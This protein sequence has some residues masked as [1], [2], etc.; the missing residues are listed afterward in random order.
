MSAGWKTAALSKVCSLIARGV[1]PKY[2]DDGGTLV[3]NQKC[4]RDHGLN[5]SLGRRHDETAKR[6]S[7]DRFIQAG[8]VLINS[9]G[10]GTLGRVAQVR[11]PPEEPA[12][13]DTHVT[14][15]RPKPGEF[16]LDFFGY[17]LIVLEDQLAASGE[18]A[19]GQT[20]LAR[21]VIAKFEISYPTDLA[22]Q[23]RIVAVLDDAF[24][25]IATAT[26]NAEK[27]LA[28]A[29]ELFQAAARTAFEANLTTG[30][31]Q[32]AAVEALAVASKGS[33]RTGPFGSQL[34]HSEFVDDGVA[35]LG[36]DNAVENE[37]RWGKRRFITEEKFQSLS[38]FLVHPGDVIITI[39]GTCGRCAVIPD[40][41]PRAINSKHLFCISLDQGRC[42]PNYLHAYFLHAPDARAYLEE[43]A[44]GSIMAGLN[45][46]II[47]EMPVRL[48][49]L[50][51]QQKLVKAIG[52]AKRSADT[53]TGLCQKKMEAL[54]ALKQSL[55][56]R[57]FSGELKSKAAIIAARNDNF[58][59]PEFAAKIVAF[60]YERHVAK[61][62]VRNFGT[63]KAE[64]ILHMV[65]AIGGIDLGRQP[66]REAAG[67]DDA[68]H[69][70]ATWDLARSQNFF[71]FNKRSSGGH[72][73]EKLSSYSRM[74]EDARTAIAGTAVERAIELLVDMDRDFAELIA[75][76]YAAWN[77]LI[78]DQCAAT[79]D[80][81][82]LA[83]R[84]NWHRDKLRFEPSRF[85]DAIRFIRNNSIV[86][87]GTAK[88]VGGQEALLF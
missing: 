28:N 21:S 41:V 62:R 83:A 48:P 72:D 84:D 26:A 25:A 81:I 42:L 70:H 9:T 78:I 71:R 31:F 68:K 37:F 30:S 54:A 77:N 23:R 51:A 38:R 87:D 56:H 57:A 33:M 65:E 20:E 69:R 11:L 40:D 17:A 27:N 32:T 59:T 66:L 45:M 39:M 85:H 55:L 53:L 49:A 52:E 1:A 22:E 76:T 13:V 15:V 2:V 63:V 44:Q 6:V 4:V 61:N 19:S 74:I 34:L 18:G 88:R 80:A 58:A 67:P 82:V 14:I 10:T 79:D 36:I 75:T 7:A 8:D 46:G 47:R 35:V 60:A 16:D 5:Y 50:E 64:K 86:P 3:L 43:R 73:F 24:A 12:T 29:R